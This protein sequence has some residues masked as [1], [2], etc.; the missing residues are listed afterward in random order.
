M[1]WIPAFAGTTDSSPSPF[2][3]RAGV[4]VL[5]AFTGRV[6]VRGTLSCS[7]REFF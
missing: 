5:E 2:T 6:G 3:G 7:V 4:G 1:A